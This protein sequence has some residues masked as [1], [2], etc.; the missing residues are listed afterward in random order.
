MNIIKVID[1][2][3]HRRPIQ[4]WIFEWCDRTNGEPE[5]KKYIGFFC[6]EGFNA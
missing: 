6:L 1:L 3:K 5:I 4:E 2:Y